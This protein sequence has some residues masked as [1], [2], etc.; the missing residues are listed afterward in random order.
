VRVALLSFNFGQY[1][2]RLANGL[3][4]QADV[5]LLVPRRL[6]EPYRFGLDPRVELH[7]IDLPRLRQPI[8]QARMVRSVLRRIKAFGPEVVHYQAGHM[9]FNLIWPFYRACPVVVTIHESRHHGGDRDS[10]KTPQWIM[11][12]GYRRADRIIVHGEQLRRAVIADLGLPDRIIDTVPAVPDIVLGDGAVPQLVD[13]DG[14]S[15]LFFGRIWAYKGLEFLVRA[16]PLITERVPDA[17]VVI[18]GRGE[19]LTRYRAMMVHPDRFEMQNEYIS[20]ADLVDHFRRAAVVVLPHVEASISGVVAVAYTFGKPVVATSV[21]ILPEMVEH[22]HTGLIVPPRDERALAD[23]IV[24]LLGDKKFRRELGE[25]GRV[26][27]QSEYDP[28]S[29]G[30]QTIAVYERAIAGRTR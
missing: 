26:R 21:G 15:I 17:R 22:G 28:V 8:R 2:I 13:D 12:L 30:R 11:D 27:V 23:A 9:W 1:C 16:E 24:Q 29:V 4:E 18:A 14:R 3:A 6:S 25:N 5:L 19:E 20:D 10:T 7:S